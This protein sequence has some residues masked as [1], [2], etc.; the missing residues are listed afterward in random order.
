MFLRPRNA[1][2][3]PHA[4]R[5]RSARGAVAVRAFTLVEVLMATAITSFTVFVVGGLTLAVQSA[6]E[7]AE[8][9]AEGAMR[10]RAALDRISAMVAEAGTYRIAGQPTV[11]GLAVVD[12]VRGPMP[13]PEILVVWSGGRNGGL[14]A[15]GELT[16][17]PRCDELV[18][19]EADPA[20]LRVLSET[21]FPGDSSSIDFSSTA[22]GAT[23][24]SKLASAAAQRAVLCEPVRVV[25]LTGN[26]GPSIPDV[27]AVRFETESLPSDDDLLG[28]PSGTQAWLDLPWC[29]GIAAG[30]LGLRQ[31]T[32]R[33]EL[34]LFARRVAEDVRDPAS[35]PSLPF[36]GS[37][38]R[39]HVHRP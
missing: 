32:V 38:V 17:L 16:R 35:E 37:A 4:V 7:Y 8:G 13:L 25:P 33:T 34:Q 3:L 27:P 2:R 19:Y 30:G 23:I 24:L 10:A 14:A 21:A 29:Q 1:R 11:L 5:I 12:R 6:K 31:T 15:Q 36:Y 39:R 22:F 18:V 9:Q 28:V 20:N 26:P